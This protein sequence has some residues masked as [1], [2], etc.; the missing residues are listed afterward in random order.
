LLPSQ[1]TSQQVFFHIHQHCN[2]LNTQRDKPLN[3]LT[4]TEAS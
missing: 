2:P 1:D 3:T 4:P